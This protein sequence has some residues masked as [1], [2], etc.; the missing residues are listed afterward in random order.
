MRNQP[1]PTMRGTSWITSATTLIASFYRIAGLCCIPLVLSACNEN[2]FLGSLQGS[3]K[4]SN[5]AEISSSDFKAQ[6]PYEV[7]SIGTFEQQVQ[8]SIA[9][10]IAV[11]RSLASNEDIDIQGYPFSNLSDSLSQHEDELNALAVKYPSL[12]NF[13]E[14]V[15]IFSSSQIESAE[16]LAGLDVLSKQL[17]NHKEE[18][19]A[20]KNPSNDSP[21]PHN[22]T[23]IFALTSQEIFLMGLASLPLID[24][25]HTSLSLFALAES[26][27][28]AAYSGAIQANAERDKWGANPQD[29]MDPE[30]TGICEF[31][32]LAP[33]ST[34]DDPFCFDASDNMTP[35]PCF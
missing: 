29:G 10:F 16:V 32:V 7:L 35:C 20:R 21:L 15:E 19:V 27:T 31:V 34:I 6:D 13:L 22:T 5:S 26:E 30:A 33:H 24:Q 14:S 28:Q 1:N 8:I 23:S 11:S 9:D 18:S 17:G 3:K 25:D 2:Q 12:Q 4:S